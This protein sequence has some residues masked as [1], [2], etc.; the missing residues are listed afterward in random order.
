V[1]RVDA[2]DF[3]TGPLNINWYIWRPVVRKIATY[4]EIMNSWTLNDLADCHEAMD[5]QDAADQFYSD[6][7][8]NKLKQQ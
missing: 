8:A 2:P 6:W 7:E 5:L 4:T 1:K 3:E